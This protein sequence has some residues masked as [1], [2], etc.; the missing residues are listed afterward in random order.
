MAS[1]EIIRIVAKPTSEQ[2]LS[3]HGASLS[4]AK[5]RKDLSQQAIA[6]KLGKQ[7]RKSAADYLAGDSDPGLIGFLLGIADPDLGDEYGN[8]VLKR[9]NRRL[10]PLEEEGGNHHRTAA[11]LSRLV[12]TL[13]DA[14]SEDAD[15][16]GDPL[17]HQDVLALDRIIRPLM[18]KLQAILSRADRLRGA[19]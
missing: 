10:C 19:A 17:D 1:R 4:L 15:G 8:G 5:S 2:I 3:D 11:D 7:D 12:A 13:L 6:E 9:V 14:L 18:P 16:D